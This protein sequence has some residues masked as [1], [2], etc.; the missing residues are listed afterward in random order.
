MQ[1]VYRRKRKARLNTVLYNL[2][3]G[4]RFLAVLLSPFIPETSGKIF[5]QLNTDVNSYE[6]ILSFGGLKAGT[7]VGEAKPLFARI[8]TKEM[9]EIIES[10]QAEAAAK[11]KI[12]NEIE[13]IAKINI[14]DFAKVDLRVAEIVDC[15]PVKRAKKLLKLTLN[16]G[17]DKK[18][19]VASGIAQWYKPEQLIGHRIVL[20]SNL[21]SAVLCGVESQGMILACDCVDDDVRVLFVD[22]MPIGA[23]IR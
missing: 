19:T 2:L 3:E 5:D 1:Q 6:S 15:E 14:N 23:K 8:D 22:G 12:I 4:I 21:E 11:A 10:K 17:T 9:L 18:R 13:G 20:V 7:K 16:D